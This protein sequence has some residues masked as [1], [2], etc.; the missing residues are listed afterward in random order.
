[1]FTDGKWRLWLPGCFIFMCASCLPI[2][3][4]ILF[5]PVN[6]Y[7]VVFMLHG[8]STIGMASS[9]HKGLWTESQ[10]SCFCNKIPRSNQLKGARV[11]FASQLLDTV[12]LGGEVSVAGV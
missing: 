2:L 11:Y 6:D 12:H 8:H 5:P 10:F 9:G 4:S 3:S 7:G 1:M